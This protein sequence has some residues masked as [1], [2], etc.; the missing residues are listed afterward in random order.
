MCALYLYLY[1]YIGSGDPL[2]TIGKETPSSTFIIPSPI[3]RVASS[4]RASVYFNM[5]AAAAASHCDTLFV[6]TYYYT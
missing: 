4:P 6:G 2:R 1:T 3:D 5:Y